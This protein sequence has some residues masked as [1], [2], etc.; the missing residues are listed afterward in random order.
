MRSIMFGRSRVLAAISVTAAT[1]AAVGLA[2]P[3][4]AHV[5]ANLYGTT[6]TSGGYGTAFFRVPH[7]CDGDATNSVSITMPE[8]VSLAGVKPQAKSGWQITRGVDSITWFGGALADNEFDDF[9]VNLKWPTLN[10][11]EV[12]RKVYFKTV[13]TCAAEVS[14]KS[15]Q[16]KTR[17]SGNFPGNAGQEVGVFT[18]D[19]RLGTATVGPDGSLAFVIATKAIPTGTEVTVR[20]GGKVLGNSTPRTEAWIAV[21]GDGNDPSMPAPAVTVMAGAAGH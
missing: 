21:P 7:G 1:V 19:T 9:G 4:M 20:R 13:Q 18:G 11:G 17:V 12:S 3:A 6:A 8:G 2:A 16:G 15:S 5:T 14:V 10:A